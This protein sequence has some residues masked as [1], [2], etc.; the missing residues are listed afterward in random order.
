VWALFLGIFVSAIAA[1]QVAPSIYD[2]KTDARAALQD[3]LTRNAGKT[4]VLPD[5]AVCVITPVADK[6]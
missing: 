4:I 5:G 2:G 6:T 3:I 1:A